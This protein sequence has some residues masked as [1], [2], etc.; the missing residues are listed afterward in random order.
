MKN[1]MFAVAVCGLVAAPAASFAG[2]LVPGSGA[3]FTPAPKSEVVTTRDDNVTTNSVRTYSAPNSSALRGRT[4]QQ[5]KAEQ[6]SGVTQRRS[7][8]VP[9]SGADFTK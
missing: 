4:A 7:I 2:G 8:L 9:G 1:L 3:D 6:D 5:S